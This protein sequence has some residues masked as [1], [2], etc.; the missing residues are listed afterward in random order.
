[1]IVLEVGLEG[2]GEVESLGLQ[3]LV[4]VVMERRR[5][6]MAHWMKKLRVDLL[7]AKLGGGW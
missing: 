1:V 4:G 7:V 2:L 6:W 5:R 3:G